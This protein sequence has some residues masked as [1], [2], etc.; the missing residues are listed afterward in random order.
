MITAGL[1][2]HKDSIRGVA[3]SQA[4]KVVANKR[5]AATADALR[6][7]L[8]G[9]GGGKITVAFEAGPSWYWV[10]DVLEGMEG[11][12]PKMANPYKVRI[13]AESHFKTDEVDATALAHLARMGWL[14]ESRMIPKEQ[15]EMRE[16]MRCRI[17][18]V[19]A[20]SAIKNKVSSVLL[21]QGLKHSF[22][23]L[24]GKAGLEWLKVVELPEMSRLNID[25]YLRVI[26][27]MNEEIKK[28]DAWLSARLKLSREASLLT[29]IPGIGKIGALLLMAEIGQISS[30]KRPGKLSAYAGLVPGL[31]QSGERSVT[32]GLRPDSNKYIRWI[33]VEAVSKAMRIVS[34]WKRL[35]DGIY[36]CKAARKP[37]A[38]AAVAHKII[39]AVWWVLK[40]NEPFD[41]LYEEK[42][43]RRNSSTQ[44][45]GLK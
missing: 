2:V 41:H 13:I 22:T 6:E 1:D 21:K 14:P 28:L 16:R 40:K 18:L 19:R 29:S 26:E 42:K 5:F 10:A 23:D 37:I 36:D 11:V 45:S 35:Y 38:R 39:K 31:H 24:F 15:R 20:R 3:L 7:F 8:G 4:G 9:L 30:F 34:G 43:S 17:S 44:G 27:R 32:T 12:I 33:C 25:S